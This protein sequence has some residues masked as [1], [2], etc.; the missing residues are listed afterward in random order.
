MLRNTHY[1]HTCNLD[2]QLKKDFIAS[3]SRYQL[4]HFSPHNYMFGGTGL[5][6]PNSLNEGNK[7]VNEADRDFN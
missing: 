4:I 7:P 3:C 5:M 6:S 1:F 2:R